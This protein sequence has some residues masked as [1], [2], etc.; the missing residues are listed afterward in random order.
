[1]GYLVHYHYVGVS[2]ESY[3]AEEVLRRLVKFIHEHLKT[4]PDRK[5]MFSCTLVLSINVINRL[6]YVRLTI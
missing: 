4:F 6:R 3:V 2:S 5:T 1:M